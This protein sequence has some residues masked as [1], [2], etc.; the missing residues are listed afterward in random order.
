MVLPRILTAVVGAPLMVACAFAGNLPY[1]A[2]VTG[3]I[4]LATYEFLHLAQ[5]AGYPNRHIAGI[6][7]AIL[8]VWSI[9][10]SGTDIGLKGISK[11]TALTLTLF[12]AF[13]FIREMFA[14]D[15]SS[16]I[17][18]LITTVAGVILVAWPLSH[19]LLLRE[20][21]NAVGTPIFAGR[22][23]T[24]FLFLILWTQ[25]T[26]AWACGKTL[27]RH[28]IA[29]N[30]SPKKTWEGTLCGLLSAAIMGWLGREM[31]LTECMGRGEG[32]FAGVILG[33]L[34]VF[35]DLAESFIKRCFGAK[36]SSHLLPGHG[37]ILDRFDSFLFA[38]PFFYYYLLLTGKYY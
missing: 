8:F 37:G 26:V 20:L 15:K 9:Y 6:I 27:G 36:D 23:L 17:L 5:E 18:R 13:I 11:S 2:L 25:D 4:A 22:S 3:I 31:W 35:S 30:I 28:R 34:G 10:V 14:G 1:V 38:A 16:A 7:W 32:V 24:F 21:R 33:G 12:L 29:P 19:L